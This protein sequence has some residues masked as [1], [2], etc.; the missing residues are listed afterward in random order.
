MRNDSIK[1]I[2]LTI[3]EEALWDGW[4]KQAKASEE[5]G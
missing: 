4:G 1:I 2:I 3:I 5:K